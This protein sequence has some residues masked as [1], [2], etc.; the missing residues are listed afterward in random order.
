MATK[1]I[2]GSGRIPKSSEFALGDIIV[3]VDD[4]KVFS[5]SK[6]NVVFEIGAS[7]TTTNT[8]ESQAFTTASLH[9]SSFDAILT[10]SASPNLVISG[11]VGIQVTTGSQVNSIILNATG[12]SI[13][14][15]T[16]ADTASYVQAGNIDGLVDVSS[17]TNFSVSDTSGQTGINLTFGSNDTL[18]GVASGLGTTDNVKFAKI[19]SSANISA[20]GDIIASRFIASGSNVTS[21]FVFPNP[22]DLTDF[23]TNRITLTSAKNMQFR[24]GNV[25][26]FTKTVEILASESLM[27]KNASNDG[28]IRLDNAGTG[29][30]SR[31]RIR[32]GSVEL[33]TV[34]GSGNVGIGTTTPGKK[35]EVSGSI[36]ASNDLISNR[37]L[38]NDGAASTPSIVFASEPDTG[39]YRPAPNNLSIQV[40]GGSSPIVE[41]NFNPTGATLSTPINIQSHVTASGNISASGALFASMSTTDNSN[42]KTVVYD[43]DTG[44]FSI[45]GSYSAGGQTIT[46]TDTQVLFFDNNVPVGD[47]GFSFNKNT[48]SINVAGSITSSGDILTKE[49]VIISGSGGIS[50]DPTGESVESV[51]L[52]YRFGSDSDNDSKRIIYQKVSNNYKTLFMQDSQEFIR[53]ENNTSPT[54]KNTIIN[55]YG[56]D[57]DF[58]VKGNSDSNL[59]YANAGT[60][61]VGIG[62]SSP[63]QKLSVDGNIFS[64]GYLLLNSKTNTV[65][66]AGALLYSASNEFYLGFS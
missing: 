6:S 58:I 59:I 15:V 11:G 10:S 22:D 50:L 54:S 36:S 62:F 42:F 35:L 21:G 19:T 47:S 12:E 5:K 57:I 37:L 52:R 7:T 17:Q 45:T 9:T 49:N 40:D 16:V 18:S 65:G 28:K 8:V 43:E 3:N 2:Y 26:Q 30:E 51:A 38:V 34:S 4:S 66:V 44:K 63:S 56:T 61:K 55:F 32:T 53:F 41:F 31:F 33:V 20:S 48:D 64:D 25:F 39:I 14:S 29:I 13:A 46:G 1:L 27:L 24:A 60:D 23:S